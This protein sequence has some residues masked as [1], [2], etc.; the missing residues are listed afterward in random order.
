MVLT[1]WNFLVHNIG[2]E[3]DSGVPAIQ[4]KP[5]SR[6]SSRAR[7]VQFWIYIEITISMA[8]PIDF[9]FET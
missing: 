7:E 9:A 5:P 2:P 1:R 8:D 4:V 6:G 3:F